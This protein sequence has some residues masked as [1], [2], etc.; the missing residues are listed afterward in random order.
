MTQTEEYELAILQEL[1][2]NGVS[3]MTTE[4]IKSLC[5]DTLG[6]VN[7]GEEFFTLLRTN[8]YMTDSPGRESHMYFATASGGFKHL[9]LII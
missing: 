9:R 2:R 8:G 7:E 1:I 6:G 5:Y 3:G 4:E